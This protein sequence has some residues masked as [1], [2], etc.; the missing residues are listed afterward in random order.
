[1]KKLVL[2][3]SLFVFGACTITDDFLT[4]NRV[5]TGVYA[6]LGVNPYSDWSETYSATNSVMSDGRSYSTV[7]ELQFSDEGEFVYIAKT[8]DN[9][10]NK[11]SCVGYSGVYGSDE[12]EF[13]GVEYTFRLRPSRQMDVYGAVKT[14]VGDMEFYSQRGFR[15]IEFAMVEEDKVID[16]MSFAAAP[17]LGYPDAGDLVIP[18]PVDPEIPPFTGDENASSATTEEL[19]NA[20]LGKFGI[21]NLYA[22]T[23]TYSWHGAEGSVEEYRVLAF[24]GFWTLW[25]SASTGQPIIKIAY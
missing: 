10:G 1:M 9:W 16:T 25:V 3:I 18:D 11:I 17:N 21:E 23:E 22:Y 5:D 13:N 8:S 7:I 12:K 4:Q 14:Y 24:N 19:F 6:S 15:E 2:L 20:A